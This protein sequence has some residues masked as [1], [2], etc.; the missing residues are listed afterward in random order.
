MNHCR[1]Q[2]DSASRTTLQG[3]GPEDKSFDFARDVLR[4]FGGGGAF[5]GDLRPRGGS[6]V[7]MFMASVALAVGAIPEGLPAAVTIT[8]A[9]GVARMAKRRAIIR[10]LPAV[11]ALG[12]TT[13]ICSDKTGTLTENQ[14]TVQQVF[15]GGK[16]YDVTGSGYEPLGEILLTG[17]SVRAA[18]MGA[19][20][21]TNAVSP[22][23][24]P[25]GTLS[26]SGG[27]GWGEGEQR[28]QFDHHAALRETL[29]A[30]LRNNDSQL[31]RDD[32][33]QERVRID[34]LLAAG[35]AAN[36]VNMA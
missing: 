3:F 2:D 1:S 25:S 30:G 27:E 20:E 14:M 23:T 16:F 33:R 29:L 32:G 12:S 5:A 18:A 26:P 22:L 17:Q 6:L 11:E 15:A 10:K 24:R 31:V 7:E 9:I 8:L 34:E 19:A 13:V 21:L 28:T 36:Q 35:A 4:E